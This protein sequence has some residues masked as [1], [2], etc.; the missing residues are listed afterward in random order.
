MESTNNTILSF[1]EFTKQQTGGE[2][3]T[4]QT[5]EVSTEL[6]GEE[7]LALPAP[8]EE[9]MTGDTEHNVPTNMMDDEPAGNEPNIE[10][11]TGADAVDAHTDE[12][13][14]G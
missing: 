1:E 6:T 3:G 14:E 10:V 7:P 5:P 2:M 11:E 12:N 4:D 13:Q 8:A 9:P